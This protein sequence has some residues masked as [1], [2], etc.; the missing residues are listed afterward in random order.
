MPRERSGHNPGTTAVMAARRRQAP[1]Q[2]A[3]ADTVRLQHR[4]HT[5]PG[6]LGAGVPPSRRAGPVPPQRGGHA[7][8]HRRLPR[9]PP[10]AA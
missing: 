7:G 9:I 2:A 5:L 1:Q 6:G 8:D 3:V 4:Q 10:A